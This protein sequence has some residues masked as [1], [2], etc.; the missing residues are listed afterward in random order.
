MRKMSAYRELLGIR[1]KDAREVLKL[2]HD[3]R[4]FEIDLYW[5]RATY[6]WAFLA[7]ALV[8]YFTILGWKDVDS[9]VKREALVIV[10]ALGVV[11]SCAWYLAN[12]GSKFWQEN[13]ENHV[14]L[15]EKEAGGSIHSRI[16]RERREGGWRERL[17]G[18]RRYSLS[19]INQLLSL[20]LFII[21]VFLFFDTLSSQYT[22]VLSKFSERSTVFVFGVVILVVLTIVG[23]FRLRQEPGEIRIDLAVDRRET[24][25]DTSSEDAEK[26]DSVNTPK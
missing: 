1:K 5:R 12:R 7:A 16:L 8:A 19:Q 26:A 18:S 11:F 6:F 21:F 10:T 15:L 17:L 9:N 24:D 14:D 22:F 23:L 4:K 13:W 20:F 2:A 25:L 3:I